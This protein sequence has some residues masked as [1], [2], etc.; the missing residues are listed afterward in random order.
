MPFMLPM[1]PVLPSFH[2][3][4]PIISF[5]SIPPSC[6]HTFSLNPH[7]PY[8]RKAIFNVCNRKMGR[9]HARNELDTNMDFS[10]TL[11]PDQPPSEKKQD[12][13]II[14]VGPRCIVAQHEVLAI[15]HSEFF[16]LLW[17]LTL[18]TCRAPSPP[19][20][21]FVCQSYDR[22][23]L[24]LEKIAILISSFVSLPN[25]SEAGTCDSALVASLP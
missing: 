25:M 24:S 19:D 18:G 9:L 2:S 13:L 5:S 14:N 15:A 11:G 21:S 4:M 6:R 17:M 12:Q 8:K 20:S 3:S 1:S 16:Q 22:F 23:F 7:I 10:E